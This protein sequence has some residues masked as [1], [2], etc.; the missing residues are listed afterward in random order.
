MRDLVAHIISSSLQRMFQAQPDLSRFIPQETLDREPNL[1]RH[2]A[3]HHASCPG[4]AAKP[5]ALSA[6]SAPRKLRFLRAAARSG[7]F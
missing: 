6:G 2:P 5:L 4:K 1:F 7:R 3:P